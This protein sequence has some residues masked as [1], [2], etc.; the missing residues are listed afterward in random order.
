MINK[1]FVI[2][3]LQ[4][5]IEDGFFIVDVK[6]SPSSKI[7]VHLDN[8]EGIKLK[9]CRLVHS[10]LYPLIEEETEFF[11]LEIS[12]PG[13]TNE[14]KVW[15]QYEKI[16]DKRL[17]IITINDKSISGLL[18]SANDTE[19]KLQLS[20]EETITLSYNEIRKAKQIITF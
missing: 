17:S 14:L 20:K 7:V 15:Q 1:E 2:K 6:I 10:K 4:E 16:I 9:D 8:K 11:E 12:S 5:I 13:L 18:L 19:I 3:N